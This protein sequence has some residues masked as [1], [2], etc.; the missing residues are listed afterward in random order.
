MAPKYEGPFLVHRK[1]APVIFDLKHPSGKIVKHIHVRDLKPFQE[2]GE[3]GESAL[4]LK[5]RNQWI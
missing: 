4:R 2:P 1:R 3:G 5:Q